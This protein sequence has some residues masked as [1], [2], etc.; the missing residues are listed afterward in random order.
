MSSSISLPDE[1]VQ[2]CLLAHVGHT[3]CLPHVLEYLVVS[4]LALTLEFMGLCRPTRGDHVFPFRKH[5]KRS[6]CVSAWELISGL[7]TTP[8]ASDQGTDAPRAI[9]DWS[10][11]TDQYVVLRTH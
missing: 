2:I 4:G 9:E 5:D 11:N 1:T 7:R 8:Q 6:M 3:L 10:R